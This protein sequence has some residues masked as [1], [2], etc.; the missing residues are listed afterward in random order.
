MRTDRIENESLREAFDSERQRADRLH[1]ALEER[2]RHLF[3]LREFADRV[4]TV[5]GISRLMAGAGIDVRADHVLEIL[6]ESLE[7]VCMATGARRTPWREGMT[8][9]ELQRAAASALGASVEVEG[10]VQ[11]DG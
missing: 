6:D 11:N 10:R 7:A 4:D 1:A 9:E 8:R 2:R 3:A 5:V